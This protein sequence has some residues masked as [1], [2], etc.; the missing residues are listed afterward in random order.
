MRRVWSSAGYSIAC[1]TVA[2][3]ACG[4]SLAAISLVGLS[5]DADAAEFGAG[6]WIKGATDV[7]AGVVPSQSGFYVRT[8]V[9]HYEADVST[10]VFNGRIGVSVD[11]EFTAT[12]PAL[13]YV[14]K[15]KFLGGTYAFGIVPSI[16]AVDVDVGI[17]LPGFTGP[18][19]NTFGPTNFD[20][21]DHNLALGDTG[22]IP[23]VLGWNAGN[24]H[25][26]MSAFGLAP[27]GDYDTRQLANASLNRWAVM[28]RLAATYF[29]PS[30]EGTM[31]VWAE[32][33]TT[34]RLQKIFNVM[35]DPFERAD[36][37]S[38]TFWDW[39]INHVGSM[40]GVMDQM[41]QFVETFKEFPPRSFP[42][43]F[44]PA[45]IM[46]QTME[47]LKTRKM[48]KEN[49]DPNRIRGEF[50]KVIEEKLKE[51]SMQ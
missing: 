50:N 51:R 22:L 19:G 48:L 39:Q 41:F 11:Q 14:T 9:Y 25:W 5:R 42:P 35:Q 2:R 24:F 18:R 15:W 40:Y 13:T 10:T 26:S 44:N 23:I 45:N 1:K 6:P 28:P 7:F 38:N 37:T 47:D 16:M 17:Q 4:V 21:S 20:V 8:D 34:L 32:P 30:K 27:T 36:I 43:S 31:G 46:E 49:I 12:L 33:F 29:D 3:L